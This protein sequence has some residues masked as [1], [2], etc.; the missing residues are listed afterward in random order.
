MFGC[1]WC[2]FNCKI[3]I[4]NI[5]CSWHG[6]MTDMLNAKCEHSRWLDAL[7]PLMVLFATYKSIILW[8]NSSLW[9]VDNLCFVCLLAKQHTALK[10]KDVISL[11]PVLQ[12]IAE[13]PVMWGE[14]YICLLSV[15]HFCQKLLKSNNACSGSARNVRDGVFETVYNTKQLF[16]CKLNDQQIRSNNQLSAW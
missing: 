11:L 9:A 12:G 3:V 4:C 15:L 5:F 8:I 7:L 13:A 16:Y 6:M 2:I 10:R 1:D 14:K